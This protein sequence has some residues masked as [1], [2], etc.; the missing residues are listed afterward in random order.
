MKRQHKQFIFLLSTIF[1]LQGAACLAQSAEKS[2]LSI[3]VGYYV[4]NN[5]LPYVGVKVKTKVK[6]RFQP[7]A[8]IGLN[9]FLDNGAAANLIGKVVTNAHGEAFAMIPSRLKKQWGTSVKHTFVA[10]FA[11]NAKYDSTSV[12]QA[13][14]KAK[15]LIDTASGRS[16]SATVME[17]KDTAWTPVKGVDVI[18]AVKRM[19]GDLLVNE[20][21]TFSTDSTGKISADFKRDTLPG[22]AHGNITLVAKIVDNDQYGN[23]LIEK[24]VPWGAKFIPKSDF[25][26]RTL[27][28]T[29]AKAP[30]WLL[31]MACSIILAVWTTLA[32]LVI[33][34]LKIRKLGREEA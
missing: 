21:P 18:V 24:K 27:F 2:S 20:T 13:V 29:G 32:M 33:N 30:I 34:I 6:G 8:G 22:D 9:L 31:F 16:I 5:K 4:V 17:M 15:I 19:G 3:G 12:D 25:N 7:V 28:A 1:L 23:L 10:R 14:V 11:G 26:K